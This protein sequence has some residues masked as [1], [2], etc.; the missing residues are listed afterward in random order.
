MK[1]PGSLM[2][3]AFGL[4]VPFFAL[5]GCSDQS[6]TRVGDIDTPEDQTIDLD[7]P[8]G[9]FLAVDEAPAFGD[10]ELEAMALKE[11]PVEDGYAGLGL[12]Q[13]AEA[14]AIE[15]DPAA[16]R[17]CLT[18]LWGDLQPPAAGE[19]EGSPA[20]GPAIAWDGSLTLSNGAIR[21]LNVIDFERGEDDLLPRPDRTTIAW[22]STTRGYLDGIRVMIVLP[23][24]SANARLAETLTIVAGAFNEVLSTS[25]LEDLDRIVE[26]SDSAR[27]S[28]RAFRVD[29]HSTAATQGFCRGQ[30]SKAAGDS[31]GTFR[32]HWVRARDGAS[33]GFMRGHYGVNS[34]G[35]RV[36]FGKFT[37][38]AGGFEGFVRGTWTID[39]IGGGSAGGRL[40]QGRFEGDW[41]DAGGAAL[42]RVRGHWSQGEDGTG[43]F[44]GIW[45]G[46]P[47]T[48]A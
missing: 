47:I 44:N 19:G 14:V 37:N 6:P 12:G 4:L 17:Y 30:W 42:G 18:L 5:S 21:L 9:G 25:D 39:G 27:V 20:E 23:P 10:S 11:E 22:R 1:R 24:D 26:L 48:P 35:E 46:G 16:V 41:V 8:Y 40:G 32:G 3:L 7:D 2:V 33:V 13:R 15:G 45:R 29:S 43:T 38:E 36:F 28:M 31:V 34:N